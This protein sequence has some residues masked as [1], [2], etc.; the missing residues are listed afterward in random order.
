MRAQLPYLGRSRRL[1][2]AMAVGVILVAV[3]PAVPARA[4]F[5]L[6]PLHTAAAAPPASPAANPRAWNLRQSPPVDVVRQVK[7]AVVNIHSERTARAGA[8]DLLQVVPSQSR[9]NGMGTGI[10]ID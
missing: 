6:P 1:A 9:I 2:G 5:P 4:D 10:I 7:D 8:E 3:G